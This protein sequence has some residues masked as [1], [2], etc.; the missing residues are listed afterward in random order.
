MLGPVKVRGARREKIPF[1]VRQMP[2]GDNACIVMDPW[3]PRGAF[4]VG[5]FVHGERRFTFVCP[6]GCCR[7]HDVKVQGPNDP[8]PDPALGP[9]WAWDGNLESPTLRPSLHMLRLCKW[10]GYLTAGIFESV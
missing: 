10:H 2:D 6:C 5:E 9:A 3:I 8:M 7:V 1:K 4:H